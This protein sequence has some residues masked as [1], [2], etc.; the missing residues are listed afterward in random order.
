[1][2]YT[3][4]Y[5]S[6]LDDTQ[7]ITIL[8]RKEI[9][10]LDNYDKIQYQ[11]GPMVD[12]EHGDLNTL[13]VQGFIYDLVN[14]TDLYFIPR[15]LEDFMI[16]NYKSKYE[17]VCLSEP[18]LVGREELFWN[19]IDSGEEGDEALDGIDLHILNSIYKNDNLYSMLIEECEKRSKK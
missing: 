16:K 4:K 18:S 10:L 17:E 9:A 15:A 11:A 8:N 5:T 14:E 3:F 1:M 19:F 13:A 12:S 6:K 7:K 2:S